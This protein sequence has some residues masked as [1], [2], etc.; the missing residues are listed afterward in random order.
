[1]KTQEVSS[2]GVTLLDESVD[3]PVV[4]VVGIGE[5][6]T[7]G[8]MMDAVRDCVPVVFASVDVLVVITLFFVAGIDAAVVAVHSLVVA[9]VSLVVDVVAAAVVAVH[10]VV[11]VVIVAV[12]ETESCV[13]YYS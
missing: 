13:G 12:S 8:T 2:N 9:V 6:K 5:M 4:V 10:C 11:V 3:K 1:M 7:Q